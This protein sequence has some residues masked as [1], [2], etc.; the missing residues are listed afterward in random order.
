MMAIVHEYAYGKRMCEGSAGA[1]WDK[2]QD[3]WN[4]C[5]VRVPFEDARV[6]VSE[7]AHDDCPD[8]GDRLAPVEVFRRRAIRYQFTKI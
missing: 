2:E 3:A 1:Y 4:H 8:G 7:Q 5:W 6:E